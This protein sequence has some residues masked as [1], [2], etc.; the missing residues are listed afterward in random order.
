MSEYRRIRVADAG[1]HVGEPVED[2]V[3]DSHPQVRQ[4]HFS[5]GPDGSGILQVRRPEASYRAGTLEIV[6]D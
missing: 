5:A 4:N 1:A 3:L 6:K 2:R